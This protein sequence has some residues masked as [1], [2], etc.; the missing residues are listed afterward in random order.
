MTDKLKKRLTATIKFFLAIVIGALSFWALK[1]FSFTEIKNIVLSYGKTAPIVYIVLISVLPIF[2]VPILIFVL[3][4][5]LIFGLWQGVV[6]TF[7]GCFFNCTFMFYI[8]R[9]IARDAFKKFLFSK[10]S[11]KVQKKLFSTDQKKLGA[12]FFVLRLIPLVSYN[13]LNYVAGLTEINFFTYMLT[14]LIGLLP[15]LVVFLNLG[16][17]LL[18]PKSKEF[19][20]AVGLLLALSVVSIIILKLYF[21]DEKNGEH[22]NSNI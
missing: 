4:A 1:K 10:L 21:G 6:Y 9:F 18:I 22:N 7:I 3:V 11:H 16:D 17:K 14:S 8:S 13:V 12:V 15:G 2:L 19:I 5:G 20:I